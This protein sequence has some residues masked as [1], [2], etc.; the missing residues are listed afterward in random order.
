MPRCRPF[1]IVDAMILVAVAAL[2]MAA[3]RPGWNQ[4]QSFW[5]GIK[6][7]PTTQAYVGIAQSS[8]DDRPPEPRR[9]LRL[10]SPDPA[11]PPDGR[12]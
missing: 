8:L 12:T 4:F 6:T 9:G 7:V 5:A 11:P 1:K 10:D 3:M 2:G